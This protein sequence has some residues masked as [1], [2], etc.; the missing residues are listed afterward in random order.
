MQTLID[1]AIAVPLMLFVSL[2]VGIF[3]GKMIS[4]GNRED[5]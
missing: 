2:T 1:I 4:L 5:K 3:V